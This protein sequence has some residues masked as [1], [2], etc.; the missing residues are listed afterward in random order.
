MQKLGVVFQK[1]AAY[2]PNFK[3]PSTPEDAI[4]DVISVWEK[5]SIENGDGGAFLSH[6]GEVK[7]WL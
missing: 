2:A 5:A 3:G 7:N 6:R 1:F 4:K